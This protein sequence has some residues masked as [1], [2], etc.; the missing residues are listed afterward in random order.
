[1]PTSESD[2]KRKL[3]KVLTDGYGIEQRTLLYRDEITRAEIENI[4]RQR[5]LIIPVSKR[6][7]V[8]QEHC[9][10]VE[11]P[12]VF[13]RVVVGVAVVVVAD[14]T[15]T[16][17]GCE[18]R[19]STNAGTSE[20]SEGSNDP[21]THQQT[22]PQTEYDNVKGK[23]IRCLEPGHMPYQCK[24]R[25]TPASERTSDG[26]AQGQNNSCESVCFLANAMLSGGD[27]SCAVERRDSLKETFAEKNG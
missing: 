16:M 3:V 7:N 11:S 18:T 15:V 26:R 24:P 6:K 20:G 2:V 10:R 27:D 9:F 8:K 13:A 22:I 19:G 5:Y 25:V 23:C 21:P 12:E 17:V 1:M 14:P 4:V